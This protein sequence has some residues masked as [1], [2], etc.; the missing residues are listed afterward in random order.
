MKELKITTSRGEFLLLDGKDTITER[1]TELLKEYEH[2]AVVKEMTEEQF[3]EVVSHEINKEEFT[4]RYLERDYKNYDC[5]AAYFET[6]R[7]SFQ[8]LIRSLGWYLWENPYGNFKSYK[9]AFNGHD[10]FYANYIDKYH[11]AESKTLYN[12]IL[13]RKILKQIDFI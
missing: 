8:S 12:P 2:Y 13:L 11:Q 9:K 1:L 5:G 6:A 3:A 4:H 10:M 7:E